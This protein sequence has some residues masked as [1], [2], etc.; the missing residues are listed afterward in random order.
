MKN[1]LWTI[2][3]IAIAVIFQ[4]ALKAEDDKGT[5][6]GNYVGTLQ[7]DETTGED[8]LSPVGAT[9]AGLDGSGDLVAQDLPGQIGALANAEALFEPI[10]FGFDQ[11]AIGADERIKLKDVATF[12]ASNPNS[13][14]WSRVIVTGRELGLQ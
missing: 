3:T 14:S 10:Y 1:W 13:G 6:R 8:E 12:M 5:D 9:I 4:V 2:S 11:Y 7:G